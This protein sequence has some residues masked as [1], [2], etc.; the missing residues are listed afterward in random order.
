MNGFYSKAVKFWFI[1]LLISATIRE[2][3]YIATANSIH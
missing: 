1:L 3:A 2:A